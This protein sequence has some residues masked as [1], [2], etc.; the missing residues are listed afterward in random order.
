MVFIINPMNL[1]L[2][3][4]LIKHLLSLSYLESSSKDNKP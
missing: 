3:T 2:S 4:H 1:Y